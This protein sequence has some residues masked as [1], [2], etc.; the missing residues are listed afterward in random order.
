MRVAIHQPEHLPWPN[1]FRKLASSDLFVML[2]S[3]QFR[4][5]YFQNR[6]KL[7]RRDGVPFWITAPISRFPSDTKICDIR[8]S[9]DQS[10]RSGYIRKITAAYQ[11]TEGMGFLG[12]DLMKIVRESDDSLASLNLALIELLMQKLGIK[13]PIVRSSSLEPTGSKSDLN[14]DICRKLGATS[15]LAGEGS[16]SDYLIL[17]DFLEAGITVEPFPVALPL[18]GESRGNLGL[19]VVDLLMLEGERSATYFEQTT[20]DSYWNFLS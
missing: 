7:L 18:Y 12:E 2:D 15:Y 14:L 13:T 20:S 3:V 11:A 17:D 16:I 19:S 10:W 5:N 1:F 4:K 8:L 6:N 9:N